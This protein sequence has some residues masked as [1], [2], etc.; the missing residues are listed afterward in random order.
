MTRNIDPLVALANWPCGLM[1][2]NRAGHRKVTGAL[3]VRSGGESAK[4]VGN[5]PDSSEG[6]DAQVVNELARKGL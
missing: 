5:C 3:L 6:K 2:V 4:G 1:V